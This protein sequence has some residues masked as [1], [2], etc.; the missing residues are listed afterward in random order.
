MFPSSFPFSDAPWASVSPDKVTLFEGSSLLLTCNASGEPKPSI[1]WTRIASVL[2]VSPSLTIVNVSRPRTADNTIQYQCTASN[3]VGT[4]ITAT[5]NVT[6]VCKCS[7]MIFAV[8]AFWC[9]LNS[10]DSYTTL[11]RNP[12]LST[13]ARVVQISRFHPSLFS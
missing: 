4:P 9:P 3:R 10:S 1:P 12:M 11:S 8:T 5:V 13:E 6:V 2:S 7:S